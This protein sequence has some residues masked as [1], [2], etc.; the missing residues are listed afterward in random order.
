MPGFALP[1]TQVNQLAGYVRSLNATAFE[2]KPEGDVAAG[3]R[4][5]HGA[6]RCSTC[7]D[8]TGPDLSNIARQLT[9]AELEHRSTIQ[10]RASRPDTAWWTSFST[11][12]KPFAD[13]P[14]AAAATTSNS[15]CLP[16]N[17]VF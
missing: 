13:S 10:A 3:E 2:S 16:A 12:A 7:H 17:S 11:M 6:G 9:L 15:S 8:R 5:F 4:F 1:E 14:V